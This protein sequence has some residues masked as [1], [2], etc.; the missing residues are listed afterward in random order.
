MGEYRLF[1]A[2]ILGYAEETGSVG[3]GKGAFSK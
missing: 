2:S 3:T 1:V